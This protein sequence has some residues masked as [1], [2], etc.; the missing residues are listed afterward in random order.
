MPK[1]SIDRNKLKEQ[2]NSKLSL[3]FT[4]IRKTTYE[5]PF[6]LPNSKVAPPSTLH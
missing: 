2:L 3:G 1:V 4:G 5:N 6:T